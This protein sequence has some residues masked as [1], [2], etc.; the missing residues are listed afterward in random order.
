MGNFFNKNN[1]SNFFLLLWFCN[2]KRKHE[3]EFREQSLSWILVKVNHC[4][5]LVKWVIRKG[6]EGLSKQDSDLVPIPIL[7]TNTW[8]HHFHHHQHYHYHHYH[9][10]HIFQNKITP[11]ICSLRH[12]HR[13]QTPKED[14]S[15][16]TLPSLCFTPICPDKDIGQ[17]HK[18]DEIFLLPALTGK[19]VAEIGRSP[20]MMFKRPTSHSAALSGIRLSFT[21]FQNQDAR[22]YWETY[23]FSPGLGRQLKA[24]SFSSIPDTCH[25]WN[26]VISDNF[27]SF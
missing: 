6:N 26:T 8:I 23:L 2:V 21:E 16:E 20:I 7:I 22:E 9:I 15:G 3:I 17:F 1:P 11:R 27:V 4:H 13:P 12:H 14:L 25:F 5:H 10:S 18:T 19:R 24:Y